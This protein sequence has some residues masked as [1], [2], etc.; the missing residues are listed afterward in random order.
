MRYRMKRR[1]V[2][3]LRI[4]LVCA[5]ALVVLLCAGLILR[6]RMRK[7]EILP[8]TQ[9]AAV[10]VMDR[11]IITLERGVLRG[12]NAQGKM[13]FEAEGSAYCVGWLCR[14]LCFAAPF[15]A[16]FFVVRLKRNI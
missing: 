5:L 11:R 12:F 3:R 15:G 9:D 8:V 7:E 1:Y 6:S 13:R 14:E 4:V 2:N 16:A 10:E